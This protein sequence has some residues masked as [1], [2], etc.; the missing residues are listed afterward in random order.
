[1]AH[2]ELILASLKN[3][4]ELTNQTQAAVT[5]TRIIAAETK[6]EVKSVNKRLDEHIETEGERIR[7]VEDNVD[8]NKADTK[9]AIGIVHS[10]VDWLNNVLWGLA[11][12]TI[13]ILLGIVGYFVKEHFEKGSAYA[14]GN[15]S[16]MVLL[17]TK[18]ENGKRACG[19]YV[20][21]GNKA[22]AQNGQET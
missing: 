5:Q 3:L 4:T 21:E 10:R 14:K 7:K 19:S 9:V 6:T 13:V 12:A 22:V 16:G 8:E 1:M 17:E 2:E 15:K 18:K 11:G 20:P